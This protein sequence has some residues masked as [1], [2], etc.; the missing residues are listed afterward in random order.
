MNRT[1]QTR[2]LVLTPLSADELRSVGLA[3]GWPDDDVRPAFEAFA[4]RL[5]ASPE[6]VGWSPW[7]LRTHDGTFIGDAGFKSSPDEEQAT[8]LGYFICVPHRRR[9][10][11]AEAV[12]ALVSWSFANGARIVRAE[13][14]ASN[15]GSIG[16]MRRCGFTLDSS[17]GE[18]LWFSRTRR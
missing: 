2:R 16:V 8:E 11:A 18:M 12:A 9:G 17:D 15:A 5:E 3:P 10:Y 7:A 6:D 1:I 13:I 14:H 4:E